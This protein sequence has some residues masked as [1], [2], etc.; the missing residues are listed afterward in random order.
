MPGQLAG[1]CLTPA[2]TPLAGSL[3]LALGVEDTDVPKSV[4]RI[5]AMKVANGSKIQSCYYACGG[6]V[7]KGSTAC[8]KHLLR[9]DPLDLEQA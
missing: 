4:E 6:W 2:L 9:R 8:E 3:Q 1:R 7:M 5:L